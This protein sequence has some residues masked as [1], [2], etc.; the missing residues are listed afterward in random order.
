[1]KLWVEL[2]EEKDSLD[3]YVNIR[4]RREVH[5]TV[6]GE[7]LVVG[8]NKISILIEDFHYSI[9]IY[10][11]NSC[12]YN[13]FP[14]RNSFFFS[15]IDFQRLQGAVNNY[16]KMTSVYSL[17][18][19]NYSCDSIAVIAPKKTYQDIR[20]LVNSKDAV[21]LLNILENNFETNYPTI[22]TL[23]NRLDYSLACDIFDIIC[24]IN[25]EMCKAGYISLLHIMT[26]SPQGRESINLIFN[27]LLNHDFK[28]TCDEVI[29]SLHYYTS[30]G[31]ISNLIA[32][33]KHVEVLDHQ[34]LS[35]IA[36]PLY[37]SGNALL[38]FRLSKEYLDRSPTPEPLS[39]SH[40]LSA[41]FWSH[42]RCKA[43]QVKID[44][45]AQKPFFRSYLEYYDH[46]ENDRYESKINE[47]TKKKE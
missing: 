4:L 7:L 34:V 2:G 36:E 43:N 9:Y 14:I 21:G 20:R 32:L 38:F 17:R 16:I 35:T 19:R 1:M 37:L 44:V 27:R 30:H 40:V 15:M 24:G 42:S 45:N 47:N 6:K 31:E 12:L 23:E 22:C 8:C 26:K 5:F 29:P 28:L 46:V 18:I 3:S 13:M 25:V 33:I 41:M 39:V 11:P 10:I